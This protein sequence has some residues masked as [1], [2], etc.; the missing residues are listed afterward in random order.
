NSP[1]ADRTA[2]DTT[3][4]GTAGLMDLT[5]GGGVPY[6]IGISIS[7]L[8]GGQFALLAI[9]AGLEY[10]ERTG[11]GQVLDLSMQELSAWLTQFSWNGKEDVPAGLLWRCADGY[12]Y[13]ADAGPLE[14]AE[15]SELSRADAAA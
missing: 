1:L 2:M 14:A 5:R 10:R 12:L 3:I 13:A 15:L 11:R 6:K 9:L 4:Q 7:D 8:L